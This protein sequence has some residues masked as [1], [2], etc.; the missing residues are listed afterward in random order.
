MQGKLKCCVNQQYFLR[1]DINHV[2]GNHDIA[3]P[4]IKHVLGVGLLIKALAK[5]TL[6]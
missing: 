4:Y 2:H 6:H 1:K 3:Q 5:M